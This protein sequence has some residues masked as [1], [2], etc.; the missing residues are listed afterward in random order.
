METKIIWQ[1]NE[2]HYFAICPALFE[3]EII[4]SRRA[5]RN[6]YIDFAIPKVA[7]INI[8]EGL[9]EKPLY[10]RNEKGQI[11]PLKERTSSNDPLLKLLV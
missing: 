1:D 9:I 10:V 4:L 6:V 3:D 2:G 5:G 7:L 11:K 8:A